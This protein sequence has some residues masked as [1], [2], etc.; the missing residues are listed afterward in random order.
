M[1]LSNHVQLTIT[2]DSVGVA[3][4]GFGV[5]LI[6]SY[7]APW[8]E[9]VR[10]YNSYAE[11]VA[12]GF[13]PSSP[14]ALAAAA[15][16][17]QSPRPSVVAIGRGENAP[18]QKYAINAV[19]LRAEHT[20]RLN[21]RGQGVTATTASYTS[22]SSTTKIDIHDGL[23]TALN[24]VVGKNYTASFGSLTAATVDVSS[25]NTGNDN[26]TT[27]AAHGLQTGDG[28]V[29][30]T[31]TGTLPAGLA[32]GTDYWVNRQGATVIKVATSL[33]NALANTFVDITDSGTGTHTLV[34]STSTLSPTA[35]FV[36]T[37]DNVVDWFSLE[38]PDVT[39]LS[40]AQT[41]DDPGV[42]DDLAAIQLENDGWYALYTLFNSAAYL[43]AAAAWIQTHKKI[44]G[45][46]SSA[47]EDITATS[48]GTAGPLDELAEAGYSRTAGFYHPSPAAM[49]G[50]A[51]LG[52]CLPREPGSET[53]KFRRLAG[54]SP[55]RLTATQRTNLIARNANSYETVAGVNITF[56]GTLAGGDLVYVDVQ[57]GLDWLEDDMAKGVFGALAG[58]SKIPYTDA[59][60]AVIEA[61]VRASIQRGV[62]RGVLA[63]DPA[64]VVTVPRVADVATID[65]TQRILRDVKFSATLAGAV[66]GVDIIGVVSF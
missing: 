57:R 43:D 41:H 28:P 59:G 27:V 60:I 52:N 13:V 61:E 7:G 8:S 11:V 62:G 5:P 3:R 42:A 53:W 29:Q 16:F 34:I 14:E 32:P 6:L 37:G 1:T 18:T 25:V 63:S 51:W 21:V 48:T 55:V 26:I 17:G 45:A 4:A 66:H 36:V 58:A 38:S 31:T 49:A 65:K 10:M 33:A 46:D 35:P 64:P 39:G 44:Y 30:F 2:I 24:A 12:D 15:M 50:A 54:V 56:E 20:Y 23:V 40:I 19:A 9:R 47:S 22:G